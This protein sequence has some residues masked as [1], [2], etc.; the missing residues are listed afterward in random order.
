MHTDIGC[1]IG[2]VRE[3][4]LG[5]SGHV[6]VAIACQAHAI[7]QAGQYVLAKEKDDRQVVLSTLLYQVEK[8]NQGF[9]AT[10]LNEVSWSPGMGLDLAGPLGHGFDLPSNLQRLGLV[11]SGETVSRLLPLIRQT[12][13]SHT[14]VALF[15]DLSVPVLPAAVEV[16]PLTSFKEALDWPDFL[17]LDVPLTYLERLRQELGLVNGAI[18]PCPA[19]VLVTTPLP[20]TGLAQ[21]GACAIRSRRGWK[22]VCEDGPVFDL[23]SLSW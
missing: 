3:I 14:G 4:R 23:K 18:L 6:E 17:A 11:A 16:Y 8:S 5:A 1:S 21:C 7:P 12:S 15:T 19:Q 22:L 13:L 2:R 9:W 10:P 20:C